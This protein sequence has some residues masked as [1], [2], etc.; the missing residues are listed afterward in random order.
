MTTVTLKMPEPLARQVRVAAEKRHTSRSAI[1]RQAVEKYINADIPDSEQPSAFDLVKE[2]A[3]AVK[4]PAD[5][6][7]NPRLMKGYGQ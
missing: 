7:S 1:V 3:G 5:L 6:S 2:F 4:G